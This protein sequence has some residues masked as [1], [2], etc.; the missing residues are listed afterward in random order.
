M[1]LTPGV[2]EGEGEVGGSHSHMSGDSYDREHSL[3]SL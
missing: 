2:V 1:D 3:T